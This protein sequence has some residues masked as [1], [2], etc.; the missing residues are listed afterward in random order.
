MFFNYLKM[1]CLQVYF[2]PESHQRLAKV[3]AKLGFS[4]VSPMAVVT[5]V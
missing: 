4:Y 3:R 2:T 5:M 1:C